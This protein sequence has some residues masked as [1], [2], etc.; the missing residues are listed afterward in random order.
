MKQINFPPNIKISLIYFLAGSAWILLSD[1]TLNLFYPTEDFVFGI[2]LSKGLIFVVL[3]TLVLYISTSFYL[4][5]IKSEEQVRTLTEE[6]LN[7][8]KA[9]RDQV[10]GIMPIA[11][12]ILNLDGSIEYANNYAKQLLML[13]ESNLKTRKFNSPEWKISDLDGN[14]FPNERLPF[15][16]VLKTNQ[17]VFDVRHAIE[18]T[19][20]RKIF[21]SIN[22]SPLFD[23]K[24]KRLTNVVAVM[25]DIT[26]KINYETRLLE[27]RVTFRGIIDSVNVAI[28]VQNTKGKILDI[29]KHT[30]ELF[31]YSKLEVIGK[32]YKIFTDSILNDFIILESK[33]K[34]VLNGESQQIIIWGKTKDGIQFPL[35]VN[36]TS[37]KYFGEKVLISVQRDISD[38]VKME[39]AL[40][41]SERKYRLLFEDNPEPIWVY[42]QETLKFIDINQAATNKYGYTKQEFLSMSIKDI[43]PEEDQHILEEYFLDIKENKGIHDP[44]IIWRHQLKSGKIIYVRIHSH[45]II[46]DNKKCRI[47]LANDIT[48]LVEKENALVESRERYKRIFEN[49]VDIYYEAELDGTIIEMSPSIQILSKGQFS[50]EEI[51][52]KPITMFYANID[53]RNRFLEKIM[54]QGKVEDFEVRL[55]NKDGSIIY[56]AV[57]ARLVDQN[58]PKER[59]AGSIRDITTRKLFEDNLIKAIESAESANRLKSEFLAQMSHEIRT[60]LNIIL[61]STQFIKDELEQ[62]QLAELSEIFTILNSSGKRIT[63]TVDSILNMSELQTGSYEPEFTKVDLIKDV[64]KELV[65]EYNFIAKSKNLTLELS[66]QI[67]QAFVYGDRYSLVQIFANLIDNAIKYTKEGKISVYMRK[68]RN[69]IIVEVTDTGIGISKEFIPYLFEAFRQ[70]HQGYTR[71]F[72][73]NGL[74]LALVHKFCD[75]NKAK[76]DVQSEI[77][78][79]STF[80]VEFEALKEIQ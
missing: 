50:R 59:I 65:G 24:T 17:P 51:I 31:G 18:L 36:I 30:E 10:A 57:T 62:E 25:Q 70:E 60:P 43:R 48:D 54:E 13:S 3:T 4:K 80:K 42:E 1:F 58:T 20:G 7:K 47:V 37:G 64:L 55:R 63:R 74:G 2:N 76:I 49:I 66:S 27:S 9:L 28:I 22:A 16:Q 79:G 35:E 8:E 73:G 45:N 77:N 15:S 29:N 52:G 14:E 23:L 53:D 61:N 71:K 75:I 69:K 5:K 41:S 11:I 32:S 6:Q 19:N 12:T 26:E 56:C 39:E 38:R 67:S 40:K 34:K 44:N 46:L 33:I 21:I 78:V 72:E 68:E